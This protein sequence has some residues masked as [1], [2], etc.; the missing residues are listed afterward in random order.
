MLKSPVF[1]IISLFSSNDKIEDIIDDEFNSVEDIIDDELN[2]VEDIINDELNNVEDI[3]GDELNNMEEDIIEGVLVF[4]FNKD[5]DKIDVG[6][7]N[8]VGALINVVSGENN[9]VGV[10]VEIMEVKVVISNKYFSMERA[11]NISLLV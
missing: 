5:E 10:V 6:F 8:V 1:L 2:S 4:W 3:I 11:L 7:N 9:L